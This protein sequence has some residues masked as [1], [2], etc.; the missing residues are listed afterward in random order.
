LFSIK[1]SKVSAA[2]VDEKVSHI[3]H[4]KAR[5]VVGTDLGCLMQ[6]AGRMQLRGT[7]VEALHIAELIDRAH[8]N[9]S[10]VVA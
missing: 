1:L 8:A 2:I 9:A 5:Y 10:R 6:I 4:S 3:E 7:A